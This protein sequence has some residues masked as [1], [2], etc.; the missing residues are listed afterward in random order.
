MVRRTLQLPFSRLYNFQNLVCVSIMHYMLHMCVVYLEMLT[1]DILKFHPYL[2]HRTCEDLNEHNPRWC[3]RRG[4]KP[5]SSQSL[6]LTPLDLYPLGLP[7]GIKCENWWHTPLEESAP[8]ILD[9]LRQVWWELEYWLDMSRAT[10]GPHI[11][12]H[13]PMQNVNSLSFIS[14]F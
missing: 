13:Q 10:K 3:I 4:S 1:V 6:D 2:W 11:E 5:W 9:V 14:C 7:S 12:L 8:V